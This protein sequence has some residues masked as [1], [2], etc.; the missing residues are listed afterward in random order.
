MQRLAA[1]ESRTLRRFQLTEREIEVLILVARG[2]ENQRIAEE[3]HISARTARTH[4]SNILEKLGLTNRTQAT[5]FALRL[6]LLRLEM[7]FPPPTMGA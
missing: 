2:Y 3:L 1:V 4:V 7:V 5:L 6:G